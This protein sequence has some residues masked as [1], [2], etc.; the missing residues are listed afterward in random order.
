[1]A[2]TAMIAAPAMANT[3]KGRCRGPEVVEGGR[4]PSGRWR[5]AL[6]SIESLDLI[7]QHFL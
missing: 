5:G 1:M 2:R 7:A 4:E 6:E 3:T